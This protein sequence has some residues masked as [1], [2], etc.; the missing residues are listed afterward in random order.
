M[1][2]ANMLH[3]PTQHTGLHRG[4]TYW[5][6]RGKL[7]VPKE[8]FILYPNTR[9]GSDSTPVVGWAGWDHLGQ[10][11]ALAGHYSARKDEGAEA[12]ELIALLAGLQEIV[13]WLL[14]WHNDLDPTFGQRMG[15]FFSS[16]TASEARI[17]GVTVQDL[18]TWTP[19]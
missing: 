5:R 11:R 14:Q 10:A 2:L 4:S 1:K 16:F 13:P 19:E 3:V 8:R 9:L 15:D 12:P 7:D 17:H 18:E 6:L